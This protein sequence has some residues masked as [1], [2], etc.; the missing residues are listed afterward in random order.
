MRTPPHR[1]RP[2]SIQ[3]GGRNGSSLSPPSFR[4]RIPAFSLSL[5]LAPRRRLPAR[6]N[7]SLATLSDS[8]PPSPSP[9][10]RPPLPPSP[11][12]DSTSICN[13][14]HCRRSGPRLL[15]APR[16][17][18]FPA[19][20]CGGRGTLV[21]TVV[22]VVVSPVRRSKVVQEEEAAVEPN[23]TSGASRQAVVAR[24]WN[25][26][27][28]LEQLSASRSTFHR[29]SPYRFIARFVHLFPDYDSSRLRGPTSSPPVHLF[30]DC[31]VRGEDSCRSDD[32]VERT[33]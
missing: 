33:E 9:P 4:M 11:T 31:V 25:L 23:E 8:L 24:L 19:L 26:R 2:D 15:P 17:Q 7:F 27:P 6:V 13:T 28:C 22:V 20:R 3:G 16:S 29:L 18:F 14:H 12:L 10:P 32:L 1:L 30:F 21:Q 5:S